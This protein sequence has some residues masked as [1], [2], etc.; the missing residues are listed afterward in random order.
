[1][2]LRWEAPGVLPG[3]ASEVEREGR[4]EGTSRLRWAGGP[5]GRSMLERGVEPAPVPGGA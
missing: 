4:E 1:M 5:S 2:L 3:A